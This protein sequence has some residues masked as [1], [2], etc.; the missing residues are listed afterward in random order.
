MEQITKPHCGARLDRL[1][2]CRWHSSMFAIV[3]FGLL[4]CWS[5]AVGGLILAQ[6]KELGWTDNSTTATFSAITTAGMFLGALVGGIIGDKTG[7]RN[8]F[9]LYEA[10]HIASMVVGA[11]SPNMDFLIACRF[12]MGVGLGALLVTLFAGFTEYMP[13][14]NRGTW[15]SRV[16]F[17]G[18]WSYPLCSLIAMGLTPL[19]SAEWNWRVQLLIPA[20]LSLI[21]TALAW[22]YFPE[23][24]RW[25]ESRGR[26]Q[27]A[28]KVM[29]S[30]EEGVIR[31]TGKPLPSVVIA[32]DGKAPQAVP[33]S[34]LLTGVL[35]KRVILGSCVLIAMNVV[36][37][38]LI[39]W[40]P[41]IFMTRG[42]I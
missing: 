23:S 1:P 3:A 35:L 30:I 14:R 12:V 33:Y 6:L 42:L 13:G 26:Y 17:I 25:L 29:R 36:Q 2:D 4:V 11:F 22:R 41:T 16:S 19:I 10:I 8:A 20:I 5:N 24:P 31:Q 15:S 40:L 39:N 9:I 28:E 32:D 34:A 18:N 38:T 21:A 27:E 7:R 37:Y